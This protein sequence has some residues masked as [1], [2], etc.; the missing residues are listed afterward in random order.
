MKD[1]KKN[2][3]NTE[4]EINSA[5]ILCVSVDFYTLYILKDT[6]ADFHSYFVILRSLPIPGFFFFDYSQ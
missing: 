6:D 2:Y 3:S 1:I 4:T 5:S